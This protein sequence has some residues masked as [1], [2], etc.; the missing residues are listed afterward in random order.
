[1]KQRPFLYPRLA[2]VLLTIVVCC[3]GCENNVKDLPGYGKKAPP[4]EE[5]KDLTIYMSEDSKMKGKLTSPYMLRYQADT[6]AMVFPRTLHVDFYNDSLKTESMMDALYG[7]YYQSLNKVYLRDSVVV[8]NI[9]RGDTLYC[10]DL[11]WDQRTGDFT[12][13][14]KVRIYSKDK[15][16]FGTGMIADQNFRYYTIKNMQGS[17]LTSESGLPK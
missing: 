12:T 4:P 3:F 10:E 8:K 15:I 14:K 2:A 7:K 13:D 5:G 1:M 6:P 11:W 16:T 9:L 17:I